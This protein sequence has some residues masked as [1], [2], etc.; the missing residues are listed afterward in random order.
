MVKELT[1]NCSFK[2]GTVSPVKF[3][4]GESASDAH[5][6]QFQSQ[7]LSKEFGGKIPDEI[8]ES[9]TELKKI[10]E[11]NRIKFEELCQY[12]FDEVNSDKEIQKLHNIKNK[13]IEH[14]N[15][16][17]NFKEEDYEQE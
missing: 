8:I 2:N 10:S 16:I 15:K 3:F 12:V 7:W 1:L 11:K 14:F 6:I 4:I 13:Q 9:L 17:E 5:P